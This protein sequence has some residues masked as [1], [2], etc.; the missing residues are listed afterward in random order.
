MD[1]R[2]EFATFFG[3]VVDCVHPLYI[4][5]FHMLMSLGGKPLV[6]VT[7]RLRMDK[8]W[9]GW[10]GENRAGLPPLVHLRLASLANVGSNIHASCGFLTIQLSSFFESCIQVQFLA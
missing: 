8:R 1:A 5:C 6:R 4:C 2:A 7:D 10:G 3:L 9:N